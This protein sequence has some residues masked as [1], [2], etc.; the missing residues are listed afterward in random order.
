MIPFGPATGLRVDDGDGFK[1]C[2]GDVIRLDP[3]QGSVFFM[4]SIDGEVASSSA[5]LIEEP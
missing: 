3:D 1:V 4:G 2:Y 5:A